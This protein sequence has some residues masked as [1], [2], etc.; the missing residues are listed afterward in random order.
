M[1]LRVAASFMATFQVSP[2]V[3][4]Q[5]APACWARPANSPGSL[6][7]NVVRYLPLSSVRSLRASAANSSQVVGTVRP[8]FLNRSLR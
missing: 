4:H 8:Y 5:E 3:V 6:L 1:T 7:E 2:D